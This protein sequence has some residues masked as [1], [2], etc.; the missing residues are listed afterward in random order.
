[1]KSEKKLA[2]K[3]FYSSYKILKIT[4]TVILSIIVLSALLYGIY[5]LL[6]FIQKERF[7]EPL[8]N[9]EYLVADEEFSEDSHDSTFLTYSDEENRLDYSVSYY[10]YPEWSFYMSASDG[11]YADESGNLLSSEALNVNVI[12]DI[13]GIKHYTAEIAV[14]QGEYEGTST[15]IE[16]DENGE[17]I[18]S[19]NDKLNQDCYNLV[20]ERIKSLM[21]H[22]K[23]V[24]GSVYF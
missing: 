3:K 20:S 16:I 23:S 8:Q 17:Y 13:F 5:S 2:I 19:D 1:M 22:M 7:I 15:I 24:F 21:N 6:F 12:V 14:F 11:I 10:P 9:N 18:S 4:A